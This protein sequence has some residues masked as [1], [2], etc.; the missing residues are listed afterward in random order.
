MRYRIT[1]PVAG[2][3]GRSANV[4]FVDGVAEIDG[5]TQGRSLAFFRRHG[6]GVAEIDG[7]DVT[8]VEEVQAPADGAPVSAGGEN[9]P[10]RTSAEA[11]AESRAAADRA[12][13]DSGDEMPKRSASTEAWRAYAISQGMPAAEANTKSRDELAARYTKEGDQ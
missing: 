10:G 12:D 11:A 3:E 5:E 9:D 1:A 13:A 2:F 8:E 4:S 7:D 6:Y